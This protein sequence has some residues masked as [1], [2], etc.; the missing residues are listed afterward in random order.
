MRRASAASCK[1]NQYS[2]SIPNISIASEY[3]PCVLDPGANQHTHPHRDH[4]AVAQLYSDDDPH[5]DDLNH[6]DNY[7]NPDP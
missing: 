7:L 6:T 1:P 4:D 5:P 2:S 3:F